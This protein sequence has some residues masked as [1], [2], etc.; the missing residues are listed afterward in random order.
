MAVLRSK[1]ATFVLNR[2]GVA[3]RIRTERI[4][5][6]DV[7]RLAVRKRR[8]VSELHD[9]KRLESEDDNQISPIEVVPTIRDYFGIERSLMLEG[10]SMLVTVRDPRT[11]PNETVFCEF[12]R[13]E[14]PDLVAMPSAAPESKWRTLIRLVHRRTAVRNPRPSPAVSTPHGN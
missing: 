14:D 7:R 3:R 11:R 2:H 12:H 4:I 9:R 8:G 13:T 5:V 10:R 1:Q 6:R